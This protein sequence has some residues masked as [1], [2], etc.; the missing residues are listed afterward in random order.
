M[1]L[2]RN[3]RPRP[4]ER[5][6][7]DHDR[8]QGC[9]DAGC[10]ARRYGPRAPLDAARRQHEPRFYGRALLGVSALMG[11]EAKACRSRAAGS[12]T[13]VDLAPRVRGSGQIASSRP[14]FTIQLA[15][16]G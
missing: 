6:E 15:E 8:H 7:A 4:M 16:R 13:S 14:R 2:I 9:R 5:S 11:T 10:E 1:E 12:R 3:K